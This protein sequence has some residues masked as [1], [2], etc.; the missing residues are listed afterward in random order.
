MPLVG[1]HH[2]SDV[3]FLGE[4]SFL[5]GPKFTCCYLKVLFISNVFKGIGVDYFVSRKNSDRL[6]TRQS[7]KA[8][9]I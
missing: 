3:V 7:L 8:I 6:F 1:H 4:R 5:L 2:R 9:I